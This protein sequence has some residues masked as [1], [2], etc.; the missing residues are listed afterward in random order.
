MHHIA[1]AI[2][3]GEYQ[4]VESELAT[5]LKKK[6][7]ASKAK[8]KN[9]S[10]IDE[11][12]KQTSNIGKAI[13][14]INEHLVEFF[15]REEI[16][17]ELDESK[18]G[19]TIKRSG[20]PA[21]ALS[22]SE[23]TAIAFSY[24]VVKI[25]EQDFDKSEGVVFIDDPVS[26]FD[27]SSIHHCYAMIKSHFKEDIGQLFISTHNFQFF[28]LVK[29]WFNKHNGNRK[30]KDKDRCCEF[31]MVENYLD[32]SNRRRA[33]IVKL[34]E[35][36]RKYK[37][38]YHFL[39]AKLKEFLDSEN[40]QYEDLYTIGNVARRFFDIFADFK[41]P[42]DRNPREKMKELADRVNRKITDGAD[43]KITDAEIDMAYKLFNQ[44]SHNSEPA[45]TMEHIDKSEAIK[46]VKT[47]LYLVGG[48]DP[49]HFKLLEKVRALAKNA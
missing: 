10:E 8:E 40:P 33:K 35:T 23:R 34:D 4:K 24:F 16:K 22:E 31:F 42:D 11:L 1:V 20:Q 25:D 13:D 45:S 38:E 37:S 21:E 17:L 29:D 48:T 19:Y 36:L 9:Q 32:E 39:F 12:K 49:E 30:K 2:K 47:L 3:D 46:A 44:F 14:K 27:S 18:K 5:A 43:R 41:V 26:S 28:N 15:G 6:E 7:E